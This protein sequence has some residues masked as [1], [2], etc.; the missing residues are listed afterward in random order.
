METQDVSNHCRLV[1][2]YNSY[3]RGPKPFRFNN[4]LAENINHV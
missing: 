3:D 4:H 2:R 1:N